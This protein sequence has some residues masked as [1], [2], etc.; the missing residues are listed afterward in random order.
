MCLKKS[1][2][3]T[4]GPSQLTKQPNKLCSHYKPQGKSHNNSSMP[5]IQHDKAEF[6]VVEEAYTAQYSTG[7]LPF[8]NQCG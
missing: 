7:W 8:L 2:F 3:V 4:R 1:E 6:S 5:L